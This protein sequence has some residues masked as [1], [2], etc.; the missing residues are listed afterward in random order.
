[1]KK[2]LISISVFVLSIGGFAQTAKQAEKP[3]P[4]GVHKVVIQEVLQTSSYTYLNVKEGST[5]EWIAVPKMDAKTGET[6]YHT[7][8]MVMT[9]FKSKELNRTFPK[10]LFMNGVSMTPDGSE[11]KGIEMPTHTGKP[12]IDKKELNI[13]KVKGGITIGE[14]FKQKESFSGKVVKIKGKV[15]KYNEGIMGKNWIHLQDGTSFGEEFDLAITTSDVVKTGDV[16]ILEGKI[17]LNK[18]FGSGYFFKVIME[19]AKLVLP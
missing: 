4:Q 3:V 11:Q 16:I 10:V 17:S 5:T 1:M 19:D 15:I 12:K 6:C 18:D 13:E 7:G 2:I 9:D 14:L 8:G